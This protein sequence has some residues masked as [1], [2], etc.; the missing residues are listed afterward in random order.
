[1][2]ILAM[3]PLLCVNPLMSIGDDGK[4][5]LPALEVVSVEG[6]QQ[7]SGR[8]LSCEMFIEAGFPALVLA[9]S[10]EDRKA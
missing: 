3:T 8:D 4:S 10:R 5:N 1:M 6:I 2:L 7:C 9:G